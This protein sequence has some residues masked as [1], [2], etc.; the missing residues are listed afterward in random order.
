LNEESKEEQVFDYATFLANSARGSLNE[1]VFSASLRLV[2][3][4]SRLSAL[5]PEQI[6]K[7]E[8]LKEMTEYAK[9]G[10]TKNFLGSREE[11]LSFLDELLK[12]FAREIKRR[13][14]L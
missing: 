13:N 10:M 3:A 8:F 6:E 4:L 2:D 14:G 1:G 12:R 11:Y 7:D 5:F 9:S